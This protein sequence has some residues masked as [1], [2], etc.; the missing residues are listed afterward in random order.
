MVHTSGPRK[1]IAIKFTSEGKDTDGIPAKWFLGWPIEPGQFTWLCNSEVCGDLPAYPTVI[2]G[3]WKVGN[4][5]PV[6][7]RGRRKL[8]EGWPFVVLS[9]CIVPTGKQRSA[10]P[11]LRVDGRLVGAAHAEKQGSSFPVSTVEARRAAP[12]TGSS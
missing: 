10:T 1:K 5:F 6:S 12:G 8:A 9:F 7:V 3:A 11:V 2:L 4:S